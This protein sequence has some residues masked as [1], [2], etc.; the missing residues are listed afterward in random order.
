MIMDYIVN[1]LALFL[2]IFI[3]ITL[4]KPIKMFYKAKNNESSRIVYLSGKSYFKGMVSFVIVLYIIGIALTIIG[5]IPQ[6]ASNG[7]A[8]LF[9]GMLPTLNMCFNVALVNSDSIT[10]YL[11]RT[12]K[13][14]NIRYVKIETNKRNKKFILIHTKDGFDYKV[15]GRNEETIL[16]LYT[17]ISNIT[18]MVRG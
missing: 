17:Y 8:C 10:C 4:I 7:D 6:Y 15:R 11:Y 5:Y 3:A 18:A 1:T 12:I 16:A 14:E 13:F 2:V 9:L